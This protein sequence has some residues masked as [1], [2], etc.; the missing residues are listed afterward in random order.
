[1]VF[2]NIDFGKLKRQAFV[3]LNG[4]WKICVLG[5]FVPFILM[6]LILGICADAVFGGE[7]G[8]KG[9]FFEFAISCAYAFVA[10]AFSVGVCSVLLSD[11]TRK[12]GFPVKRHFF[13][14][15]FFGF[16]NSFFPV[17]LTKIV[18]LFFSFVFSEPV[19]LFLYDTLFFTY[20]SYYE[21]I[22]IVS[23]LDVITKLLSVYVALGCAF[24]PCLIADIPFL[25]GGIAVRMSFEILKKRKFKLFL[26]MLSLAGWYVLGAFS[27][28]VG[29]FFAMAYSASVICEYYKKLRPI[30]TIKALQTQKN[31]L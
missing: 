16:L 17:M 8:I 31:I 23:I 21:Y 5:F 24:V 7:S 3:S 22:P 19:R 1:M 14:M 25:K 26:L 6:L 13:I 15:S 30:L 28:F 27:L 12:K 29:V 20:V 9:A 10:F 2:M 18:F 4:K 11:A